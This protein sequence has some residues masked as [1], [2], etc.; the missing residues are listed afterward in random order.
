MPESEFPAHDC[1]RVTEWRT[2]ADAGSVTLVFSA[3][4]LNNPSSAFGHTFLRLNRRERPAGEKRDLL[5]VGVDYS[6]DVDTDNALVYGVKGIFGL[7]PGT[8]RRMPYYL[9][10]REYNDVDSRDLWEYELTLSPAQVARLVDHLWELGQT[11]IDY[12][13]LSENCSYHMLAL[14]EVADPDLVLLDGLHWPVIPADTVKAV[15]RTAGLV[16]KVTFR[17]SVRTQFLAR[18]RGLEGDEPALVEALADEPQTPL[19]A[20]LTD[21]RRIAV[22]DAAQDLVDVRFARELPWEPDGE[23]R[24][25]KQVLLERRAEILVPSPELDIGLPLDKRPDLGHESRRVALGGGVATGWLDAP[26][27]REA[28]ATLEGRLGLHGLVDDADGYPDGA[29]LEFLPFRVRVSLDE[30][31]PR[32]VWLDDLYLAR[33]TSLVGLSRYDRKLAWR[34]DVG[35]T[36]LFDAGCDACYVGRVAFGSG[37]ALTSARGGAAIYFLVDARVES[38]PDLVGPWAWPVRLE[39][40][41][42]LG[43]RFRAGPAALLLS[44]EWMWLPGVDDGLAAWTWGGNGQLKITLGKAGAIDVGARLAERRAEATGSLSLYF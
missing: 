29:A 42:L 8:F 33:V 21:A 9:K 4:Y 1:A 32:R 27:E 16:G 26:R 19:P 34:F 37:P 10:V 44:G 14:L 22:L 39:L 3:Y 41:P 6:A 38:G 31:A 13:Y 17:P 5:E 35:S 18:A 43:L 7:F 30:D 15:A 25:R 40:G 23:G 11:W 36:R 12:W 2:T 24:R 20:G 28:F